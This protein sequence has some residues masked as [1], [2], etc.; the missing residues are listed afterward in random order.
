MLDWSYSIYAVLR[1]MGR[2]RQTVLG[3]ALKGASEI[4]SSWM[5]LEGR[6]HQINPAP[7]DGSWKE[8]M[9]VPF[10]SSWVRDPTVWDDRE[11]EYS[12]I[13]TSCQ[14]RFTFN[15]FKFMKIITL[16]LV[17]QL[18]FSFRFVFSNHFTAFILSAASL[19]FLVL[20]LFLHICRYIKVNKN[21]H[22]LVCI[23]LR[24]KIF[25]LT[26]SQHKSYFSALEYV[27]KWI[28][29]WRKN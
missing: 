18:L 29:C 23:T 11:E 17:S 3:R 21:M 7:M 28:K 5:L 10:A 14:I 22:A 8:I 12:F 24:V 6:S 16:W 27:I 1:A 13:P 2:V 4:L 9:A 15:L 25:T 19:F 20:L 26:C